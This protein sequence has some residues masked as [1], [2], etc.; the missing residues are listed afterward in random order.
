MKCI[1]L[2]ALAGLALTGSALAQISI[3]PN[4]NGN[5]N[6]TN[7]R[8]QIT[9]VPGTPTSTPNGNA[10][11]NPTTTAAADSAFAYHW[12]WRVNNSAGS[13]QDSR[14]L[15]M[16]NGSGAGANSF[17]TVTGDN[18]GNSNNGK[19]TFDIFNVNNGYTFLAES[20]YVITN[21]GTGPRVLNTMKITNRDS[22]PLSLSLFNYCDF[23]L[24][25]NASGDT[26]NWNGTDAFNWVDGSTTAQHRA[27]GFDAYQGTDFSTSSGS[28]SLRNVLFNTARNDLNNTVIV[29]AGDRI[30]GF[31]FD[32]EIPAGGMIEVYVGLGLNTTAPVPAPGAIALAGLAGLAGL[33]RRRA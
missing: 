8:F 6:T 29:G 7:G 28:S 3:T 19:M 33:R 22:G 14:E 15:V 12:L 9:G 17:L 4:G 30:S 23:D 25:G 20:S 13:T 31:Q 26:I 32:I 18:L 11:Y 27:L 10:T 24:A 5:A 2:A 16:S 21:D 1:A